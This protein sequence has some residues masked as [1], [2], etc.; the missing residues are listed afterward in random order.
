MSERLANESYNINFSPMDYNNY[1]RYRSMYPSIRQVENL[2]FR[3]K[4][5]KLYKEK[6]KVDY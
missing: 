6:W 4:T 1:T 3:Q 5:V 2:G